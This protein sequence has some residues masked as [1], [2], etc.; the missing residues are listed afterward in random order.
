MSGILFAD[1]KLHDGR[2]RR[3]ELCLEQFKNEQD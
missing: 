3:F 2:S 1:V